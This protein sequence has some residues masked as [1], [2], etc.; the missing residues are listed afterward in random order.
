[1]NMAVAKPVPEA[2]L[3]LPREGSRDRMMS[4]LSDQGASPPISILLVE[5]DAPTLWRLQD[6]LAKAGFH[7]T[8]AATLAEKE[9]RASR[10]VSK[11]GSRRCA[12]VETRVKQRKGAA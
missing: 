6:A 9:P 3:Y 8:S 2:K 11:D 4:V 1:M 5:D 10:C 12:S 7:V